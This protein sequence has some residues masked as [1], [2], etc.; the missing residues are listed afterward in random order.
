MVVMLRRQGGS[1]AP[2]R[3]RADGDGTDKKAECAVLHW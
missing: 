3:E 2:E 1:G